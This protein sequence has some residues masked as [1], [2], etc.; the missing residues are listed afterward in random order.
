LAE[1]LTEFQGY[2]TFEIDATADAWAFFEQ[3]TGPA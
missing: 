2:I 1:R 3:R